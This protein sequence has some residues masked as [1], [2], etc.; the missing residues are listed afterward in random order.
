MDAT[1]G[2][3]GLHVVTELQ[4][5]RKWNFLT[6]PIFD[7]HWVV[8]TSFDLQEPPFISG[9]NA[10]YFSSDGGT[11]N[12][13]FMLGTVPAECILLDGESGPYAVG[14]IAGPT[15][16]S[17]SIRVN[18]TAATYQVNS[19]NPDDINFTL[20]LDCGDSSIVIPQG[21]FWSSAVAEVLPIGW[22]NGFSGTH[23]THIVESDWTTDQVWT[24]TVTRQ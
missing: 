20:V 10:F 17:A 7:F 2:P 22:Q 6:P 11:M 8:T 12:W 14:S 18:E 1:N 4:Q 24:W 15:T 16:A 23:S 3:C 5:H 19:L 21:E 13:Q 9:Q